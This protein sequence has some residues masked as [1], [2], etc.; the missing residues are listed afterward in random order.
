[1]ASVLR[2][3]LECKVWSF[4]TKNSKRSVHTLWLNLEEKQLKITDAAAPIFANKGRVRSV[5]DR[6]F[7]RNLNASAD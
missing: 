1:M 6:R 5:A 3:T 7:S 4:L 2:E